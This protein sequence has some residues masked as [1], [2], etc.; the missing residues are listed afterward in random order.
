M[1]FWA[2]SERRNRQQIRKIEEAEETLRVMSPGDGN[3]TNAKEEEALYMCGQQQYEDE[4]LFDDALFQ[5]LGRFGHAQ[6]RAGQR[7]V[8]TA[9]LDGR[10]CL[11]IVPTG[12]GKSLSYQ[13]PVLAAKQIHK[14]KKTTVVIS[15]LVSLI[16]DQLH[17]L[18]EIG[19]R[20]IAF[21]SSSETTNDKDAMREALCGAYE[22]IF[23][24]PE[25]LELSQW[26]K[27][28]ITRLHQNNILFN[29]AVDEAHCIS[30]W[31][32][33]FRPSYLKLSYL[34]L[35]FPQVP[36]V[37][38][39]ATATKHVIKDIIDGLRLWPRFKQGCLGRRKCCMF[40]HDMNRSNLF[41]E[42]RPKTDSYV[43]D[44][45]AVIFEYYRHKCCIIYCLSRVECET[46]QLRLRAKG[47]I[48]VVYHAGL[49]DEVRQRNQRKWKCGD[50]Q[51]I[52]ATCAFGMGINKSNVRL[53]IHTSIPKSIADYYQQAGRAGRDGNVSRCILF[54]AMRERC[55]I[56]LM[57]ANVDEEQQRSAEVIRRDRKMLWEMLNYC[58]NTVECRRRTMLQLFG[59]DYDVRNCLM[60][61]NTLEWLSNR[62]LDKELVEQKSA[63]TNWGG[64]DNC[65]EHAFHV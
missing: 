35:Q 8:C 40:R 24:T 27:Q 65:C 2:S 11:M 45:C 6:F 34:K 3:Q 29:F 46:L 12:F 14:H 18:N 23:L 26:I 33:H 20:A 61:V 53:V 36:I 43:N 56:Q 64:C 42:V 51:I 7:E 17:Q 47:I 9:L 54:Y 16:Q 5:A 37:A 32:H 50:C 63:E 62:R 49:S 1:A 28:L 48:T 10:D 39:T 44:I 25:K 60:K 38:L 15:P 22:I 41:W 21:S 31:G 55:R 52:A 59:S 4:H 57:L 13:L 19:I 30:A 58:E